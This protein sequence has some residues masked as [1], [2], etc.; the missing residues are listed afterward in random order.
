[1]TKGELI[2]KLQ[3][4]DDEVQILSQDW[5][6]IDIEYVPSHMCDSVI[7]IKEVSPSKQ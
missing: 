1:M 3:G 7:L 5:Q 4:L 6:D 2:E